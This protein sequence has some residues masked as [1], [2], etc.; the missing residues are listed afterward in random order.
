MIDSGASHSFIAESVVKS[1]LWLVDSIELMSIRLATSS[2]VVLDLMYTVL[3]VF[4]DVGGHAI[5]QYMPC[6][7]KENLYY[8]IILAMD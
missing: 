4:C 1:H 6:W 5:T 3:L 8:D 2:E 7:I